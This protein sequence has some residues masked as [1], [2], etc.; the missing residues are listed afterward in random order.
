MRWNDQRRWG[1]WKDYHLDGWKT[2]LV[3]SIKERC[4]WIADV[5][6]CAEYWILLT[7]RMLCKMEMPQK[8]RF[9]IAGCSLCFCLMLI[10]EHHLTGNFFPQEQKLHFTRHTRKKHAS[11]PSVRRCTWRCKEKMFRSLVFRRLG[12]SWRV[13]ILFMAFQ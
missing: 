12:S 3:F 10:N 13:S 9:M 6:F 8:L 7:L 5:A 1:W 4:S 11:I 2:N